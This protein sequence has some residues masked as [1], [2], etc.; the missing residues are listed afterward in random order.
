VNRMELS[1]QYEKEMHIGERASKAYA[2]WLMDYIRVQQD[3]LFEEFKQSNI[4]TY[5]NIQA[6]IAAIIAIEQAI[7]T[8]IETGKIARDQFEKVNRNT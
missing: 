5:G 3:A 2:L 6:R 4:N 1:D 8:D 7:K